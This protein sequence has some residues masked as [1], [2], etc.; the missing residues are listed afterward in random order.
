MI[1]E[2]LGILRD[3]A[4]GNLMKLKVRYAIYIRRRFVLSEQQDDDI[5]VTLTSYG[6]RVK[7]SAIY[8]IYSLIKQTVRPERIVLWLDE[9]DYDKDNLSG[10]L[11]FLKRFGLEVRFD[12]DIGPYTKIIHSLRA[13][14]DKHLITID[15]DIFYSEN[16]IEEMR[17]AH[18]QH[19][20]AIIAGWAKVP[21]KDSQQKLKPYT[22]WPEYHHVNDDFEYD[23]KTLFPLGWAGVLYP[24]HTFD[25]EVTNEE[26]FTRLCPKAD[27]IW[28]Y[29]M[30]LRCKAEKRI[31]THSSIA[32]YHTDL[33]RQLMTKDRLT[34][35][36]RLGGEND[37]QLAAVLEHYDERRNETM[38]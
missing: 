13:F 1:R 29:V 35:T 10:Y 12:H 23:S 21:L 14:P 5:V 22:E 27:D 37:K 18:R 7:G 8:A 30:G 24:A 2:K 16:F 36:N 33:L 3:V 6:N 25:E 19:P 32:R 9:K 4:M 20:N 11:K 34:A 26:V 31:L 15:D 17:E 38:K 28:L